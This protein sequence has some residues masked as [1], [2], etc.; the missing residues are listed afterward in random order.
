MYYAF[1]GGRRNFTSTTGV[2]ATHY[3]VLADESVA[4][5]VLRRIQ[6]DPTAASSS[7]R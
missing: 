5:D 4:D 3:D 1:N 2:R 7:G 6:T